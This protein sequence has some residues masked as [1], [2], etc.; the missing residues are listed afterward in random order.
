MNSGGVQIWDA[1]A[2]SKVRD[3]HPHAG[4]VG[5]LAWSPMSSLLASGTVIC[6]YRYVVISYLYIRKQRSTGYDSRCA[7]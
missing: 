1:A 3:M 2:C 4:R 5:A 7:H 6:Y